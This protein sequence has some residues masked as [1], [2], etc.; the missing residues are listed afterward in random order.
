M[1]KKTV[2]EFSRRCLYLHLRACLFKVAALSF[3]SHT[4]G[5]ACHKHKRKFGLLSNRQHSGNLEKSTLLCCFFWTRVSYGAGWS[6]A[7]CSCSTAWPGAV[8]NLR[9]Y[10]WLTAKCGSHTKKIVSVQYHQCVSSS[11]CDEVILDCSC[12]EGWFTMW[13]PSASRRRF[14]VHVP[15]LT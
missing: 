7:L 11:F 5:E 15:E 12:L 4:W 2:P 14:P 9:N 10:I 6:S 1:W 8:R 3:S 13:D